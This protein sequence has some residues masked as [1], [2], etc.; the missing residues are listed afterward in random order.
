MNGHIQQSANQTEIKEFSILCMN[1]SVEIFILCT[2]C[3]YCS[4]AV[5][6]LV[7]IFSAGIGIGIGMGMGIWIGATVAAK[8]KNTAIE[9]GA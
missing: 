8:P 5:E 6:L 4:D 3:K 9:K 2:Y 1:K 7:I